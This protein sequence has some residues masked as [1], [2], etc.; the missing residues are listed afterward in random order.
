MLTQGPTP[1]PKC[2]L[3]ISPFLTLPYLLDCLIFASI[4]VSTVLLLQLIG[5]LARWGK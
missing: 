1:H 4:A 2:Q 3:I 5:G